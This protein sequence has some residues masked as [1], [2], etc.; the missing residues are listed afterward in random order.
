MGLDTS[1]NCWS[2]PY[3]MF[4]RWREE[5]ARLAGLPEL[6]KMAGFTGMLDADSPEGISWSSVEDPLVPLL[7]HDDCGGELEWKGCLA[8]A[9]RL[10]ELL[11]Q[12]ENSRTGEAWMI[13]ATKRF[14]E[15]LRLAH[16][17]KE[18]VAFF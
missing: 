10:E 2:G 11:P 4:M 14:T 3:S 9:D 13:G 5:L 18:N 12:M 6:R 8:I 17:E 16:S 7:D 1:H 15:G